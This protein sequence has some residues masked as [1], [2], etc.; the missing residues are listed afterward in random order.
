MRGGVRREQRD[1]PVVRGFV[2]HPVLPSGR[3]D[4]TGLPVRHAARAGLQPLLCQQ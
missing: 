1:Q 4:L 3:N 2:Q